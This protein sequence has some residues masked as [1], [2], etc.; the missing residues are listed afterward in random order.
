MTQSEEACV[1]LLPT[2]GTQHIVAKDN[3][4]RT[5]GLKKTKDPYLRSLT[6]IHARIHM[7]VSKVN[8]LSSLLWPTV[9]TL[10]Q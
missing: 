2:T 4:K 3:K 6:Y 5:C 7:Y 9:D 8:L 10:I 1:V